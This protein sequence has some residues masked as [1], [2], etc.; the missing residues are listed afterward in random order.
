MASVDDPAASVNPL[1]G[2]T[3][4]RNDVENGGNDFPGAI[5]PLGML[6]WSPEEPWA[7]SPEEPWLAK[8]VYRPAA[9]GGYWYPSAK[10][11]G[12]SLTHLMGTGCSGVTGDIPFMPFTGRVQSSPSAD[13][14]NTVYASLFSHQEERAAAG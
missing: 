12:F 10:I 13:T 3:N 5:T 2:T 11:R 4:G 14:G 9:V 1:I 8:D 7:G 6:A